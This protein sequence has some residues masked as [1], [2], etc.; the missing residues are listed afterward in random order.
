MSDD[1]SET[2]GP[3]TEIEPKLEAKYFWKEDMPGEGEPPEWYKKDKYKS[4]SD[5]AKAYTDLEKRFGGF[6]GAPEAYEFADEVDREDTFVKT[7][8]DIGKKANMGQET[9]SEIMSLGEQML[10]VQAEM[11]QEREMEALGPNAEQR[12]ASIDGFMRNNLGDK[13]EALKEVVSNAKTVE[14]VEALIK[15]TAPSKLPSAHAAPI[16]VPTQGEI[17]RMMQEKDPSGKV[18]YHY[19]KARQDE[20]K[21]AFA[22]MQGN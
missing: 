11:A 12:L 14:L 20:V 17:E 16:N 6:T 18:I 4:V 8:A 19:S 3:S 21:D 5:Q 10:S 1:T 15:S 13:Y 22:R 2:I 9:F 7:L